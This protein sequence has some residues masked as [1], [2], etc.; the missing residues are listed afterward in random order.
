MGYGRVDDPIRAPSER[1]QFLVPILSRA[2][3]SVAT[4]MIIRNL[5]GV[6][7]EWK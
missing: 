3:S 2:E 4:R 1:F 6:E 5:D 7:N